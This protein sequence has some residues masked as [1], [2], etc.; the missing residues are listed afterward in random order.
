M[1]RSLS[2]PSVRTERTPIDL[3]RTLPVV[4]PLTRL[5]QYPFTI[6][7]SLALADRTSPQMKPR[8]LHCARVCQGTT[9][10]LVT[11]KTPSLL[12]R[13]SIASLSRTF[14]SRS[15]GFSF[16]LSIVVCS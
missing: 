15:L 11:V 12:K 16:A 10:R 5:D 9:I 13:F 6:A 8:H 14:V 4:V 2:H 3:T 7:S 1:R